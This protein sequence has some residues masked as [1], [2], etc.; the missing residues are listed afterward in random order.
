MRIILGSQSPRRKEILNFFAIPF[1]QIPSSF[2]EESVLFEGDPARYAL[3]LS[4]KKAQTLAKKFPND[5]IISADTVVFFE[6]SIYNKP[7]DEAEAFSMLQKFSGKWQQVYTAHTVQKNDEAY[8]GFEETKILFNLLTDEQIRLYHKTCPSL[9]KAGAYAIQQA[10]SILVSKIDGCY[11]NAM[12]LSVNTLR[13]LLGKFGID[14][15]M[16]LKPF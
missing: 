2:D 8:S 5:L 12:G 11:Y 16:H 9:D 1:V 13:E 4:S 10:G 6:G 14:L 15:W 7:R 3:E